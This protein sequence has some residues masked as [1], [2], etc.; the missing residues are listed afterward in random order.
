MKPLAGPFLFLFFLTIFPVTSAAQVDEICTEFGAAPS[1]SPPA[2]APPIVYGKIILSGFDPFKRPPNVLVILVDRQQSNSR[3]R[4]ER[5]GNYCFRRV[6]I[7]SGTL[8][9]EVN[10]VEVAR[11]TLPVAA[12][13]QQREDFDLSPSNPPKFAYTP[14]PKNLELYIKAGEAETAKQTKAAI[15]YLSQIVSNEGGDFIAYSK[16]GM[17]QLDQKAHSEAETA[18]RKALS[19]QVEYTPAWIGMGQIRIE[20]KQY[21]AA[22]EILKHA[23]SLHP[24]SARAHQLLGE[25][26]LLAKLGSLGAEAL[27]KALELDPNGMAE[28][29]LQLAHLYQLAGA[30][31]MAAQEYRLFL[32]KVPAHPERAKFEKFIKDNP[33]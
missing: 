26:Y 1:L 31:P 21:P 23:I 20:Q 17:L 10:G 27:K 25:A 5:S 22:I 28:I 16:L 11:R 19:L 8:V 32:E 33:Q 9:I 7:S 29:H 6:N 30:K 24:Q 4:V 12:G 14:H 2:S 15:G 3:I 13:A 18:F